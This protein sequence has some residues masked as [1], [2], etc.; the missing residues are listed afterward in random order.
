MTKGAPSTHILNAISLIIIGVSWFI[1]G[2]YMF[3]KDLSPNGDNYYYLHLMQS[4]WEGNGYGTTM[5][6]EFKPSNWFPPGYPTILLVERWLFGNNIILFKWANLSFFLGTIVLV[7]HWM[8]EAMSNGHAAFVVACLLLMNGGL[9]HLGA[10]IM[11]EM[12]FMFFTFFALWSYT[13]IQRLEAFWRSPW[14]YTTIFSLGISCLIRSIGVAAGA[15][16]FMHLLLQKQWRPALVVLIGFLMLTSPWSM[17]NKALGLQGRYAETIFKKNNWNPDEG[18]VTT[19]EDW[20]G[21]IT[22]NVYDTIFRGTL[23]V[24]VPGQYPKTQENWIWITGGVLLLLILFGLFILGPSGHV[25]LIFLVFTGAALLLWHGGNQSRYV[26]PMA[27]VLYVGGVTSVLTLSSRLLRRLN[28]NPVPGFVFILLFMGFLMRPKLDIYQSNAINPFNKGYKSY[29]SLADTIKD[30]PINDPMVVCRKPMIFH[31]HSN[32]RTVSFPF[33]ADS[34][35]MLEHL[36]SNKPDFIILDNMGYNSAHKYLTPFLNKHREM[37]SIV[38]QMNPKMY[39]LRW[40]QEP[41]E[42]KLKE[43]RQALQTASTDH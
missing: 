1:M 10:Q 16:I 31:H 28:V 39:L 5:T 18:K 2:K 33:T 38:T 12:S 7:W 34:V 40:R 43:W 19:W 17:R 42:K 9:W 15:A 22:T 4:M 23:D 3:M 25:M 29:L 30:I 36:V 8:K 37:Y 11:S 13:K 27:P 41:A 20:R 24:M 32:A 14:F 21:K 6:G 26:W 35:R